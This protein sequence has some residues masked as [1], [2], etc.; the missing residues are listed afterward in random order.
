MSKLRIADENLAAEEL[1]PPKSPDGSGIGV[2]YVDAY[3]K[4]LNAILE[5]GEKVVFKRKGLKIIL[6]IGQRTGEA[7][8]RRADHGPD[9]RNMLRRAL[10][11]AAEAAGVKLTFA[12][13]GVYLER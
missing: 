2:N 10:E 4:P 1:L 8:I 6:A 7:V 3:L 9:P 12:D 13:G 5:D 11:S